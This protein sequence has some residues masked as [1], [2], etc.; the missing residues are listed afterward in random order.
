MIIVKNLYLFLAIED[1]LNKINL[2]EQLI[3]R[4]LIKMKNQ[5]QEVNSNK[6][7]SLTM[8]TKLLYFLLGRI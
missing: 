7:S 4:K 1:I 6:S 8:P 3:K 2:F 5:N